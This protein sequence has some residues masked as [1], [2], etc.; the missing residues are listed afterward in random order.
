MQFS[1][2]KL[3]YFV[4]ATERSDGLLQSLDLSIEFSCQNQ[5]DPNK[6]YTLDATLN[7]APLYHNVYSRIAI[8]RLTEIATTYSA[9]EFFVDRTIIGKSMESL[10]KKDFEKQLYASTSHSSC[11]PC[12]CQWSSRTRSRRQRS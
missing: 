2:A 10:L 1:E 3:Q 9:N 5:L 8:D 12:R 6:I 7:A 4:F 11:D